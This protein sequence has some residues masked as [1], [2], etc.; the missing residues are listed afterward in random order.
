MKSDGEAAF[1]LGVGVDDD[2]G[3]AGD[4][5]GFGASVGGAA[6]ADGGSWGAI[7]SVWTGLPDPT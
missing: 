2:G 7:A 6:I 3:L 1:V 4:A 5:I